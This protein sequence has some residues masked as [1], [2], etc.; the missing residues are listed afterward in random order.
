MILK[1]ISIFKDLSDKD[2]SAL[3]KL[4]SMGIKDYKKGAYVFSQNEKA[5]DFYYLIK[6]DITVS[7]IDFNGKRSIIETFKDGSIFGEVYSYLNEPFGFSAVA[8]EDSKIFVIKDFRKIFNLDLDKS[9]FVSYINLLSQKCLKLSKKNQI[10]AQYTLR[11][12]IANYL[13]NREKNLLVISEMNREDLAD[14]LATTRPSLSR[15]LSKMA[16]E[17]IIAIKGKNIQILDIDE[18]KDMI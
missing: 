4:V 8:Q 12:K 11:Q 10:N 16:D 5:V 13:V 2:L 1:E 18:L 6:G 17:N 14:F 9:F 3:E 7:K 15:E